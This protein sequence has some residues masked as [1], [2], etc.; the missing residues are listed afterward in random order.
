MYYFYK[1]L[2]LYTLSGRIGLNTKHMLHDIFLYLLLTS[3][4]ISKIMFL[5][6]PIEAYEEGIN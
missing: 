5:S 4:N 3:F 2:T 6:V 1:I